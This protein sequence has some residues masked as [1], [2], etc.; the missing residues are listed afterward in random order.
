M[1]NEVESADTL[2]TP[3]ILPPSHPLSLPSSLPPILSPPLS[4]PL[5]L[6]HTHAHALTVTHVFKSSTFENNCRSYLKPSGHPW[7]ALVLFDSVLVSKLRRRLLF[8]LPRKFVT[9]SSYCPPLTR[10]Y[11]NRIILFIFT[12]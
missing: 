5:S 12:L 9:F 6:S 3:P 2:N 1:K 4:P 10:H 7:A 8:I 11:F